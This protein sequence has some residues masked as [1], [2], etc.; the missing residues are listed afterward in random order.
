M[1]LDGLINNMEL[2]KISIFF[3]IVFIIAFARGNS[4]AQISLITDNPFYLSFDVIHYTLITKNPDRFFALEL[5]N[6][7]NKP[8]IQ[9]KLKPEH[10]RF[11]GE[12]KLLP[13][14]P[15]GLYWLRTYPG[16]Q[17]P[18]ENSIYYCPVVILNPDDLAGS[19][20][21]KIIL[22]PV[23]LKP[24]GK[25]NP[26][27]SGHAIRLAPD[28]SEYNPGDSVTI[29]LSLNAGLNMAVNSSLTVSVTELDQ[30]EADFN[31]SQA[32]VIT[33]KNPE[34]GN[35]DTIRDGKGNEFL[36]RGTYVDAVTGIPR[37]NY[38]VALIGLGKEPSIN[39]TRADPNGRFSFDMKNS[40]ENDRY[41]L[42]TISQSSEGLS[43]KDDFFRDIDVKPAVYFDSADVAALNSFVTVAKTRNILHNQYYVKNH[44]ETI[45]SEQILYDR[46][47]V[48][49]KPDLTYTMNN[50]IQ[51]DDIEDVIR[52][53]LITVHLA[54]SKKG[55]HIFIYNNQS[56]WL[57]RNPLFLING[58]PSHDDSLVLSLN[59]NDIKRID[60]LDMRTTLAPFG[61]AGLG[62]ILAIYT[63]QKVMPTGYVATRFTGLHE[64]RSEFSA[65][66]H[67]EFPDLSPV[68][69]WNAAI[70]LTQNSARISFRL[71]DILSDLKV[72]VTGYDASGKIIR[73]D[74]V[75]KI[76][77]Y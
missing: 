4:R 58:I 32:M 40:T 15:T 27:N 21:E 34:T 42:S 51:F 49:P 53:I 36:L 1:S 71:N 43:W 23:N 75:I 7:R 45:P 16:G 3:V 2:K 28:K 64:Q 14:L 66:L 67:D 9:Q 5:V 25:S 22:N 8:A 10:G 72:E 59:I 70:K 39:F 48:Y 12:I 63:S 31:K 38:S 68:V 18:L 73:S 11:S 60:I 46:T 33:N 47:R 77:K 57:N 76:N 17:D 26:L 29:D 62:G 35:Q 24:T 61:L 13:D 19:R 30:S 55:N 74:R 6:D 20:W 44:E 54:K 37:S 69:Y 52:N 56:P 50:Y 41:Y 65:V